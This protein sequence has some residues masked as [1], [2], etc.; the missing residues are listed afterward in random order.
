MVKVSPQTHCCFGIYWKSS[1]TSSACCSTQWNSY[2]SGIC[3]LP[4]KK[5]ITADYL[6][7]YC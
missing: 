6:C 5:R 7:C 1:K 4:D 3:I 2:A